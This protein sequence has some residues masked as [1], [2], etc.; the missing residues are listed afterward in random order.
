MKAYQKDCLEKASIID[1]QIDAENVEKD[2]QIRK[3]FLLSYIRQ[4]AV[5]VASQ[6]A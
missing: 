3:V 4:P 6:F 2:E 5:F 1:G